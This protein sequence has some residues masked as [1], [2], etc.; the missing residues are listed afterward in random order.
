MMG[1]KPPSLVEMIQ[2]ADSRDLDVIDVRMEEIRVVTEELNNELTALKD[3]RKIIAARVSGRVKAAAKKK[4]KAPAE[5]VDRR[6]GDT[7]SLEMAKQIFDLL[8][9]EGSMPVPAIAARLHGSPSAV[10]RCVS[11][12]EWFDTT[13]GEVAIATR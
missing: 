7:Y 9:L 6:L 1:D 5:L 13:D 11:A 4:R 3:V 8:T 2:K 12:C 10:G